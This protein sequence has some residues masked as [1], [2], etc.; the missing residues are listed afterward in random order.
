MAKMTTAQTRTIV[1]IGSAAALMGLAAFGAAGC[2]DWAVDTVARLYHASI[3]PNPLL[4]G[5]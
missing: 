2:D 5:R 1:L 4:A 3:D